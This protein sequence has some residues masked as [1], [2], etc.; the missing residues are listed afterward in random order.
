MNTS[1]KYTNAPPVRLDEYISEAVSHGRRRSYNSDIVPES[2]GAI[3]ILEWLKNLGVTNTKYFV[4]AKVCCYFFDNGK[5]LCV[6]FPAGD[7]VGR[8]KD[9]TEFIMAFLGGSLSYGIMKIAGEPVNDM[10]LTSDDPEDIERYF[11]EI[12]KYA[13]S[14]V[15]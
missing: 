5:R 8:Y 12:Y 11:G 7:P 14:E 2:L 6:R 15:K 4:P 9:T 13:T 3:D 1:T 10:Q